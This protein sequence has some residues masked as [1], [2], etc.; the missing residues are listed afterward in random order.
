MPRARL[1]IG[2]VPVNYRVRAGR[3]KLHTLRDGW[4]HLRFLFLYSPTH[5]FVWPGTALFV[6]GTT[7]L[8]ALASGPLIFAGFFL[9]IHFMVL[10][11]LLTLVGF[12][13]VATGLHA[14]TLAVALKLQPLD[15]D[16]A[17]PPARIHGRARSHP[18]LP[19]LHRRCRGRCHDR[20]RMDRVGTRT[21]G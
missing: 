17:R 14:K 13:I 20:G 2:E 15:P 19:A 9:D 11:L 16:P 6:V 18:G 3:S 5:L 7:L 8:L 21:A 12:Q 1:R 10:G 4:R